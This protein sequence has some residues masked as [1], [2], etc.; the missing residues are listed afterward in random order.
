M[1]K[2]H[3]VTILFSLIFPLTKEMAENADISYKGVLKASHFESCALVNYEYCNL[4]N[5]NK[6]NLF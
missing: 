6:C 2:L 5:M 4:C 3:N 1:G